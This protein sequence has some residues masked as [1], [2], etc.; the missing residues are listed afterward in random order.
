M[1][2]EQ[3]IRGFSDELTKND[4]DEATKEVEESLKQLTKASLTELKQFAK[5]HYLVEKTM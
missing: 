2:E 4:Y 3:I 5:P 1:I